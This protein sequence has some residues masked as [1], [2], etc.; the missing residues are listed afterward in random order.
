MTPFY[1]TAHYRNFYKKQFYSCKEKGPTELNK[2]PV[3]NQS[4]DVFFT[5]NPKDLDTSPAGPANT[6]G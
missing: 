5:N 4:P 1:S 3:L 6:L 2:S